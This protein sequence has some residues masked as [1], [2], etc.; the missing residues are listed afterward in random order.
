[1]SVLI[2]TEKELKNIVKI[3]IPAID[4]IEQAFAWLSQGKVSMPPIMHI[5]VP[6][7]EGD[8]DI[9]SAYVKG[10]ERFAVKIGAGFFNNA[11]LGLPSS[12][13]MMVVI[14]AKTGMAEAVLLDNAYLT[15]VRTAA[16]GAVAAR[17]L[18]PET[19]SCAGVVGAGAQGRYQ[20]MALAQVRP[21]DRALVYDRDDDLAA[22]YALTMTEKLGRPV[23]V[24]ADVND[25]VARSQSVVTCTPSK[26]PYVDPDALHPGL[27]ITAMGADLPEKQELMPKVFERSDIIACDVRSQSFS[28]GELYNAIKAGVDITASQVAELGEIITGKAQGRQDQEQIT[29][30]DLSGTGVQDT[31]IAAFALSRAAGKDMGTAIRTD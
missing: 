10:L 18:A 28:A 31:A 5:E 16:A 23:E 24:A 6:E 25:L 7:Y 9:K 17:H 14:S 19:V 1:M 22:R 3:D 4:A 29:V 21:F 15:D 12:P 26:I 11:A 2:L 8:V 20:L 30:C 27:H 13:A